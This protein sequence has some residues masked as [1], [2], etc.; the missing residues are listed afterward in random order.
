MGAGVGIT[1]PGA[2]VAEGF[3]QPGVVAAASIINDDIYFHQ[4]GFLF[5][6]FG[7]G[8]IQESTI[9]HEG[10]HNYLRVGDS[11]LQTTLGVP[12]N[13]S[14]TTDINQALKDKHCTH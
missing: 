13:A 9:E 2:T 12:V 8:N 5:G 3:N 10:L 1:T 11:A 6:V 7:N 14:D 4:G